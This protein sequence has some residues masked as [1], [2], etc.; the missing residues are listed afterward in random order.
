M[1][2]DGDELAFA[3]GEIEVFDNLRGVF[4]VSERDILEDDVLCEDGWFGGC[5]GEILKACIRIK[6]VE[7]PFAGGGGFLEMG[8]QFGE[9]LDGLVGLLG[10]IADDGE[11]RERD[12]V[13][14]ADDQ[15]ESGQ[16]DGDELHG[17]LHE[18]IREH[19]AF[20][21]AEIAV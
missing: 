17:G 9:F 11:S 2:D 15:E 19:G 14:V 12:F 4:R 21:G 8:I 10:G 1:S 18:D 5:F 7:D 13:I 6:Q 20:D 16:G 3:D